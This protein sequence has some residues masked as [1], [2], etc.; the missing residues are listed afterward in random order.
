[1]AA[2]HTTQ[3]TS[4]HA[5]QEQACPS[6]ACPAAISG[7]CW[8][9]VRAQ[10]LGSCLYVNAAVVCWKG[11]FQWPLSS[12]PSASWVL[13]R[14]VCD[15]VPVMIHNAASRSFPVNRAAH[16]SEPCIA[17]GQLVHHIIAGVYH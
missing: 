9:R 17:S 11:L 10:S 8:F 13:H 7:C 6:A 4:L 12:S 3:K 14:R 2:G 5:E 15:G 16:G 1:M